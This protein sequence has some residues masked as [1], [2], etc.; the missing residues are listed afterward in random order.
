VLLVLL[1]LLMLLML[2]LTVLNMS[3][4]IRQPACRSDSQRA[5][6]PASQ[7]TSRPAG[8]DRCGLARLS[9]AKV[10]LQPTAQPRAL[11]HSRE[12]APTVDSLSSD[13]AG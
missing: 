9:F 12:A 13:I 5:D 11:N 8:D 2:L 3:V 4:P 6:Q 7:P 1:M 10:T